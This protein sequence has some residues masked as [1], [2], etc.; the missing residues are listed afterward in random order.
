MLFYGCVFSTARMDS[1]LFNQL[2][3]DGH[4]SCSNNAAVKNLFICH[5]MWVLSICRINSPKGSRWLK[6]YVHLSF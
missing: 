6:M 5:F 4:L 1:N 3:I 2:P